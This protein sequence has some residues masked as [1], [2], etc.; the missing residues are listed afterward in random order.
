MSASRPLAPP[1]GQA[2]PLSATL[3]GRR[4]ALGPLAEAIADRYFDE[5]P[6]DRERYAPAARD[7]EVH[8]TQWC[9]HWAVLDV[10]GFASLEREMAWLAN[11]LG[12]RGFPLEHLARNLEIAGDVIDRQVADAGEVSA[13][14]RAS[15]AQVRAAS[16]SA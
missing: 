5:F 4:I 14:L 6:E 2:P 16:S 3:H 1:T 10:E 7:W 15:A 9:L 8:D 11:V 12:S 13:R